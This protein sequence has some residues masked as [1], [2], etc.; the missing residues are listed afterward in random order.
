MVSLH[1]N[2]FFGPTLIL[3]GVITTSPATKGVWKAG[4]GK[5]VA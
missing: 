1:V 5:D 2:Y 4:E 3:L